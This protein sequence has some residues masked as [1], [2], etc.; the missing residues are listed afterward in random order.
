MSKLLFENIKVYER[1]VKTN[2]LYEYGKINLIQ[3]GG[4]GDNGVKDIDPFYSLDLEELTKQN[5]DYRRVLYTGSNQQFVLMSIPPKDNIK[6]EIHKSHD[7][8][9]RIEQGEGDVIIGKTTYKIQDNTAFIIPAGVSHQINNKSETEPLKLYSIYSP[10][11]H[12]DNL[13][14]NTNPDK[15]NQLKNQDSINTKNNL[16]E[17]EKLQDQKGGMKNNDYKKKYLEYKN[18]Y[19]TLKKIISNH[20]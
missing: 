11:E 9:V 2:G 12:P 1:F 20:H 5:N 10:P 13:V 17:L 14:Q 6:M 19:Q 4:N 18:K 3:S 7:Q 15:I 16:N 8:F